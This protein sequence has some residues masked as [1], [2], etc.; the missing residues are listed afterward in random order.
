MSCIKDNQSECLGV[1][2][3]KKC[4]FFLS[5]LIVQK[6]NR[7]ASQLFDKIVLFYRKTSS[8]L[9]KINFFDEPQVKKTLLIV[10]DSFVKRLAGKTQKLPPNF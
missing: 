8:F 5:L 7:M 9:R 10:P 1:S 2:S 6:V 3:F 4:H